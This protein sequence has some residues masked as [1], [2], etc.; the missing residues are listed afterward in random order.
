MRYRDNFTTDIQLMERE[1]ND[2]SVIIGHIEGTFAGYGKPNR[3]NRLYG[4]SLWE[5]QCRKLNPVIS[6]GGLIGELT[7]PE[8]RADS[9]PREAAIKIE[10]LEMRENGDIHGTMKFS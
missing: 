1:A 10:A 2:P 6:E 3:N 5:K 7:H 8:D 9:D 4:K